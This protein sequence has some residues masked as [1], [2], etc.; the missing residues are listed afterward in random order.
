MVVWSWLKEMAQIDLADENILK[1]RQ[2]QKVIQVED[3]LE[4]DL[5]ETLTRV[6]EFYRKFV[7]YN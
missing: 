5:D 3:G 7:P 1:L 6:L 4:S 2:I